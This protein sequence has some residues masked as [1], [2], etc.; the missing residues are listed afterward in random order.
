MRFLSQIGRG[1]MCISIKVILTAEQCVSSDYAGVQ[2]KYTFLC[3]NE[4]EFQTSATSVLYKGTWCSKCA[5]LART[6]RIKK[7]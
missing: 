3:S 1:G 6:K 7:Q 2:G 5:R 4:H